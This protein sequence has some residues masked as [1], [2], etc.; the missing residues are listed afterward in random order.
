MTDIQA[1]FDDLSW[2]YSETSQDFAQ[3][4]A[5]RLD[6][7]DDALEARSFVDQQ[8]LINSMVRVQATAQVSIAHS[9]A[10]I[11]ALLEVLAQEIAG[12]P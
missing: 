7:A 2:L 5:K 8:T 11:A 9:L 6:R 1:T 3:A 10:H 12:R 4:A